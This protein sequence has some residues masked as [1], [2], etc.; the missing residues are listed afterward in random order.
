MN[1]VIYG[2]YTFDDT[3]FTLMQGGKANLYWSPLGDELRAAYFS[4]P[5][6]FFP[7]VWQ[8]PA[9]DFKAG[10]EYGAPVDIYEGSD[11]LMRFY[12]TDITGGQRQQ[13]GSYIFNLVGTDFV[14]L[15]QSVQHLGGIY[16][17]AQAGAVMADILGATQTAS[18]ASK[19]TYLTS[20]GITYTVEAAIASARIDNWLPVAQDARENLREVLQL[21]NAA[22]TQNADGSPHIGVLDHGVQ[23]DISP[24]DTY[25]GEGYVEEAPVTVVQV[26][27]YAYFQVSGTAEEVLFDGS[28]EGVNN[29]LVT[30]DAPHYDIHGDSDLTINEQGA[31]FARITGTGKLYGKPYTVASRTLTSATGLSGAENTKT[32]DN[33]LCSSQYSSNLLVRLQTFYAQASKVRHAVA[34]PQQYGP[35]QQLGYNDPLG[36]DQVGFPIEMALTFSGITKSDQLVTADWQPAEESPYTQAVLI[37]ADDSD[38]QLPAGVTRAQFWLIQAGKGGWGGYPGERGHGGSLDTSQTDAGDG[39]NVGEG[40][41]GGKILRVTFEAA[42]LPASV[43]I[44]VGAAGSPGAANHGEGTEGGHTTMTAGGVTYSSADGIKYPLG[45]YNVLTGAR[46]GAKGQDGIYPGNSGVGLNYPDRKSIT[47]TQ[48][49]QTGTTTT[50]LDGTSMG[51]QGGHI[52]NNGG[53]GA[54]YGANGE[55]ASSSLGGG[56]GATAAL[57]GFNGYVVTAPSVPGTGGIGGNGG[58][59]G[60]CGGYNYY[61]G[62]LPGGAAGSGSVG[63]PPAQGAVLVLMAFGTPPT[64]PDDRLL[65]DADGEALFDF[66]FERL[67]EAQ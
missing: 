64:P 21:L 11:L 49:S 8:T 45:L 26:K 55:N 33:P 13:D 25:T 20:S 1:K 43:S 36:E 14:G 17:N 31:N 60:G 16:S 58:G 47:D 65:F 38:Y 22:V 40:G 6:Q 15:Y 18:D 35:G 27:E 3:S 59:G 30:F 56:A 50:W 51:E 44:A 54:A 63:G 2:G 48:T 7:R 32:I 46:Y 28:V 29:D 57:D 66:N 42:N 12:L 53:G 39:G 5:V 41:D 34:M 24:Y 10:L 67:K 61:G 62:K 52:Y 4:I 23:L 37:T 19:V 9:E